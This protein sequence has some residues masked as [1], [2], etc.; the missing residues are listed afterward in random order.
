MYLS[1]VIP[2]LNEEETLGMVVQKAIN[3]INQLKI[4][5]EVIVSDNGSTDRSKIIAQELGARVVDCPMRGNGNALRFGFEAAR[6][7][8]IIM[9]DADDSYNA[10]EV[11]RFLEEL[12]KGAELVIGSRLKG[13]ME[14]GSNPWLHRYIG[15][16]LQTFICNILFH[17]KV[18]DIHSGMRG[19][20]KEM[21]EKWKLDSKG[22]ELCTEMMIKAGITR[23]KIVEIPINF[24]KDKRS[25]LPHLKTWSHGWAV[26]KYMLLFGTNKILIWPGVIAF[27][28][29]TVL[30]FSQINGPIHLGAFPVDIHFMVLGLMLSIIGV[31]MASSGIIV[32]LYSKLRYYYGNIHLPRAIES[33]FT[34][35]K[36]FFIG[37]LLG[38]LGVI[39]EVSIL[40]QWINMGYKNI[41]AL[42]PVI[43]GFYF[44]FLGISLVVFSFIF[45]LLKESPNA[46]LTTQPQK[47]HN[48]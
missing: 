10:E 42:R 14:K 36:G 32:N 34:F 7:K 12:D 33:I 25:R 40:N 15:T 13:Q 23:T 30:V 44:V 39:I 24:Y 48:I 2:C 28:L 45:T 37:G 27:L 18:S 16:P 35:D 43:I 11:D 29:G 19:F 4:E 5:G 1:Y 46:S 38:V 47:P 31:Y 3:T 41:S 21:L 20:R 6:G 9:L 8:Y 26:L 17:T 22:F